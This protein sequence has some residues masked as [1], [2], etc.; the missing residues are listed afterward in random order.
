MGL[1]LILYALGQ[2][3]TDNGPRIRNWLLSQKKLREFIRNLVGVK[4]L[5]SLVEL[6]PVTEAREMK[7]KLNA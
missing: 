3:W 5:V 1:R 6:F 4:V 2:T 7:L